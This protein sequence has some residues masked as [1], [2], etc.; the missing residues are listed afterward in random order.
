MN[1]CSRVNLPLNPTFFRK[2]IIINSLEI[3]VQ[4]IVLF[5]RFLDVWRK[6]EICLEDFS[7]FFYDSVANISQSITSGFR[8][9]VIS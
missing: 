5:M 6:N 4:I 7:G 2:M 1:G 3:S 9:F 8:G